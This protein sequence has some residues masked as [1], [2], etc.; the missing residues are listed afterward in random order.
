MAEKV[1][2]DNAVDWND[3]GVS[4]EGQPQVNIRGGQ[5]TP[6]WFDYEAYRKAQGKEGDWS[7]PE[8]K[9]PDTLT[10]IRSALA[11]VKE[12]PEVLGY[13]AHKVADPM[14]AN[15]DY[16]GQQVG[17]WASKKINNVARAFDVSPEARQYGR[18]EEETYDPEAVDVRFG[19]NAYKEG[20][21]NL[22]DYLEAK[23]QEKIDRYR[24]YNHADRFA[25]IENADEQFYTL[26]DTQ[27]M[28]DWQ[29][30]TTS[31]KIAKGAITTAGDML[32]ENLK[33]LV[34]EKGI[35]GGAK[36]LGTLSPVFKELK[37]KY[38]KTKDPK[39]FG[40]DE[41]AL[42][43]DYAKAKGHH[44]FHKDMEEINAGMSSDVDPFYRRK[45]EAL[46]SQL[47][48]E[49]FQATMQQ[50][51]GLRPTR[52]KYPLA[53]DT[54]EAAELENVRRKVGDVATAEERALLNDVAKA[55]RNLGRGM[56]DE[57]YKEALNDKYG[58][59]VRDEQYPSVK[60][61]VR[62]ARKGEPKPLP[63][64]QAQRAEAMRRN[65]VEDYRTMKGNATNGTPLIPEETY[66]A[67]PKQDPAV[68]KS[69]ARNVEKGA[70]EHYIVN[71]PSAKP[72]FNNGY[73]DIWQARNAEEAKVINALNDVKK[74]YP[75]VF[76]NYDPETSDSIGKFVISVDP[77]GGFGR[78]LEFDDAQDFLNYMR[79]VERFGQF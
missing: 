43:N 63:N 1:N 73:G 44:L 4:V 14:F 71:N 7:A 55:E 29:P 26:S 54:T 75:N 8:M 67:S 24:G 46:K 48:P 50:R 52:V 78:V 49:E 68:L 17:D 38:Q 5:E 77:E 34:E 36:M 72:V 23:D 65:L 19:K 62:N 53:Y 33:A 39:M 56:G 47:T 11:R 20:Y 76:F 32:P 22:G 2:L 3:Y 74:D 16:M 64:P 12:A 25:P 6:E 59:I 18:F 21:D 69:M 42:W 51:Y 70:K 35:E 30:E 57:V 37:Q 10:K 28:E 27:T 40:G 13:A 79:D 31:G 45:I 58:Q 60:S 9:N 61:V 41:E 66:Y 15:V